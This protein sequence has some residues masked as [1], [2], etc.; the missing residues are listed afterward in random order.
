MDNIASLLFGNSLAIGIWISDWDFGTRIRI[1]LW[2]FFVACML[3]FSFTPA[4]LGAINK[5][6]DTLCESKPGSACR[7]SLVIKC[8]Q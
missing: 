2:L 8:Q 4:S 1:C 7:G 6:D 5:H 3:Y